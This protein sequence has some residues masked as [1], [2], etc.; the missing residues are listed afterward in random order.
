[1][2]GNQPISSSDHHAGKPEQTPTEH[3]AEK[4]KIKLNDWERR[5]QARHKRA[6]TKDDVVQTEEVH[7]AYRRYAK[8]KK[9]IMKERQKKEAQDNHHH[10]FPLPN[11]TTIP[12][13]RAAHEAAARSDSPSSKRKRATP[14]KPATV[15]RITTISRSLNTGAGDDEN[16]DDDDEEIDPT[17]IKRI[18]TGFVNSLASTLA[19]TRENEHK[20]LKDQLPQ[21][22]VADNS[23]QRI[24]VFS[25]ALNK[26]NSLQLSKSDVAGDDKGAEY[27]VETDD[28]S[29]ARYY[30]ERLLH[31]NGI[32]RKKPTYEPISNR[33]TSLFRALSKPS[34]AR[35]ATLAQPE[36]SDAVVA[37]NSLLHGA[38]RRY[39]SLSTTNNKLL[40]KYTYP[41]PKQFKADAQTVIPERDE[42]ILDVAHDAVEDSRDD[43]D[44]QEQPNQED[45]E[46]FE[47][48]SVTPEKPKEADAATDEDDD[49]AVVLRK[50]GK[51]PKRIVSSDESDEDESEADEASEDHGGSDDSQKA[52]KSSSRKGKASDDY[53][54]P[55][56]KRKSTKGTSKKEADPKKAKEPKEPK[57]KSSK[58]KTQV[59]PSKFARFN[60]RS[61][62]GAFR[63]GGFRGGGFR[64]FGKSGF[65]RP[66]TNFSA[67]HEKRCAA[68]DEDFDDY[69]GPSAAPATYVPTSIP[70]L[71]ILAADDEE[72]D[73]IC[74]VASKFMEDP[75]CTGVRVNLTRALTS[76][77]GL[78][79][80]RHGQLEA[81]KRVLECRSTLVVLPTGTGKSLCYL[82]P[83]YVLKRLKQAKTGFTLVVVPTISLLQDQL[84]RIPV[85]LSG[86]TLSGNTSALTIESVSQLFEKGT[87][88]L[89]VTP[90][91]LQTQIWK[92]VVSS[93]GLPP[94][95]LTCVDEAHCLSE[96][97]H[98]FR[99]SYLYLKSTIMTELECSCI[100][101]LTATATARTRRAV[102]RMLELSEE[103]CVMTD[104]VLPDNLR[105]TATLITEA[106]DRDALLLGL[107]KTPVFA[108]MNS[109]IIYVMYQN[110]A[111]RLSQYLRVR[112]LSVDAYHA[113]LDDA[114]RTQV[115]RK[116]MAGQLRIVIATV[117]FG[118]GLDKSDV[119]GI[120]HYSLP[121]STENYVQEC[122]R[123]GRDGLESVCHAFV[124][125]DDYIRLRSFAYSEGVDQPTIWR[126]LSKILS[127][128]T[129]EP[130]KK[131]KGVDGVSRVALDIAELERSFDVKETVLRTLLTYIDLAPNS[132]IKLY[133]DMPARYTLNFGGQ[134]SQLAENDS[135]VDK[136]LSTSAKV[137]N[138]LT[139][140][141]VKIC[142]EAKTTPAELHR[143][144]WDLQKKKALTFTSESPSFC[145]GV[146]DAWPRM[147]EEKRDV[148]LNG[149]RESLDKSTKQLEIAKVVKVDL[150]Y[151]QLYKSATSTI[152]EHAAFY[153]IGAPI[154]ED[155]LES[156]R[157]AA[158]RACI[159]TYFMADEKK[160]V[161]TGIKDPELAE[162]A[163]EQKKAMELDIRIFV[164]QNFDL[165]TTGRCVARIFHGLGSPRFPP[166]EWSRN[167]Q[168]NAYSFMN[169]ADIAKIGQNEIELVRTRRNQ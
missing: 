49:D 110:Q 98:N 143:H 163:K 162:K 20:S 55:T 52:R 39:S 117:A 127:D 94:V 78:D 151:E 92:D 34:L 122:G 138:S 76:F 150:L 36:D 165:L 77:T 87:D 86:E 60:N 128:D 51:R 146:S 142:H 8:L 50:K 168:W 65:R 154:R 53:K 26:L 17:P 58:L 82:L 32:T 62:G 27:D 147:D 80:F 24:S 144:L 115:Q 123:A 47:D 131:R 96:W 108:R 93:Q 73:E 13:G 169:F 46:T 106:D 25:R 84:R 114:T 23:Q 44:I 18:R 43:G 21:P 38:F 112:S 15:T 139:I 59:V 124:S 3:E 74:T 140:E 35:S 67:H 83:S 121:R 63:T 30:V 102:C 156:E 88:I 153:N 85:A 104:R 72:G 29:T 12:A 166:L 69:A 148:I 16:D 109:I 155:S 161:L 79:S 101:G 99:Q 1:M 159:S 37:P 129:D 130:Q 61:R 6:P 111:D 126:F 71:D 70:E 75:T 113:G 64:G 100:L 22:L 134:L 141:T 107:L 135:F 10:E 125:K 28:Q 160:I 119:R 19:D 118:L 120:I 33:T 4:L 137:A 158:L 90:E 54:E 132:P 95:W 31:Q 42:Q 14:S 57:A 7:N 136:I 157:E 11:T 68:Q 116:F 48:D 5:F 149:L 89:F 40:P 91:R 66:S 81:I 97:S 9:L 45:D 103:D 167:K 145:I 2:L 105:L 164:N 56:Q 41:D 133:A 152:Y